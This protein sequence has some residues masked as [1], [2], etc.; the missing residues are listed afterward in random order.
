MNGQGALARGTL[1]LGKARLKTKLFAL[2]SLLR[3]TRPPNMVRLGTF[4]GGWWIPE[5]DPAGSVAV[6]VGAGTDVTFDLELD[7]LGYRVFS[8][9]P[10]PDALAHLEQFSDRLTV[11][12]VGV[13]THS[14]QVEFARDAVWSESWM[15]G[16]SAPAHTDTADTDS[17]PVLTVADLVA[18][19][20][21]EEVAV[22]K[23]DIEGAEHAVL[24]SML[25]DGVRPRCL[26]VEFD[27]HR[28][29]RVL[30]STRL[31]QRAGYELLQIE[32][33]NY[34]FVRRD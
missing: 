10:T 18:R 13:W 7:R 8:V 29:R 32:D 25:A 6:C 3:P 19:T 5:V 21:A 27:D 34:I 1:F 14:G 4:Y 2:E 30:A 9:D 17:M 28:V 23:L 24:R 20:G 26:C 22:L 12:P 33:L 11:I 31:L 16:A 15:I